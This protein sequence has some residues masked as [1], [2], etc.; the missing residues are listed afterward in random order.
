MDFSKGISDCLNK[1]G[2]PEM[3]FDASGPAEFLVPPSFFLAH[4]ARLKV[5]EAVILL[6]TLIRGPI[7]AA[8]RVAGAIR[9]KT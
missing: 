7:E 1:N 3:S 9:T 4:V 8:I 2:L 5:L 6:E